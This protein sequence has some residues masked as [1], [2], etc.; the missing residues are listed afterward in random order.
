MFQTHVGRLLSRDASRFINEK[1]EFH[2]LVAGVFEE[3]KDKK[4]SLLSYLFG[5][6]KD[7]TG[8]SNLKLRLTAYFHIYKY[9]L[10]F[11]GTILGVLVLGTA[12]SWNLLTFEVYQPMKIILPIAALIF[13]ANFIVLTTTVQEMSSIWFYLDVIFFVMSCLADWN[14]FASNLWGRFGS[15]DLFIFVIMKGYMTLRFWTSLLKLKR[16]PIQSA[17]K[18]SS[19]AD[20]LDEV[21]LVW[22]SRSPTLIS[23]MFPDLEAIWNSL[24]SKFGE[25]F[26][27]EVCDISIYC[28]SKDQVA[29]EKLK[30]ELKDYKLFQKGALSFKRPNFRE[31]FEDHTE[32][33]MTDPSLPTSRTLVAFC[34]SPQL[35]KNVKETKII[36]DLAMFT[37]GIDEHQMDLVIESYGGV[38]K[39]A[40]AGA[41]EDE[42]AEKVLEVKS[43]KPFSSRL[44]M[45]SINISKSL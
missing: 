9:F 34:G 12:I 3:K 44:S 21:H 35:A 22:T 36:N 10:M 15:V 20:V 13:Q 6:Q 40:K 4:G 23:Q 5:S 19:N 1:K 16:N 25:T 31:I 28:T 32:E 39:K 38:K 37:A 8:Y 18:R 29:C 24:V 27:S 42:T 41:K 43:E 33:C 17:R 7:V 45:K 11:F 26:T 2:A 14:F 30:A